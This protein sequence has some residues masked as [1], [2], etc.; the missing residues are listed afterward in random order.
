MDRRDKYIRQL[1][2]VISEELLP[3]YNKYYNLIDE[4]R[5]DLDIPI[6]LKPKEIPALLRGFPMLTPD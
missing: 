1:E 2:K 3:V 4:P 6:S 5:P